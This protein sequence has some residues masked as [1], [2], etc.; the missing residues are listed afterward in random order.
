MYVIVAILKMAGTD[1]S[2]DGRWNPRHRRSTSIARMTVMQ[3]KR[4]TPV[5]GELARSGSGSGDNMLSNIK[6]YLTISK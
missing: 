1:E 6:I 5:T 3:I 2:A 4:I